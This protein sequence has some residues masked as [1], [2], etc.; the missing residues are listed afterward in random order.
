MDEPR[1][2]AGLL[3]ALGLGKYAIL[4]Q[5]EEVSISAHRFLNWDVG[6]SILIIIWICAT[7]IFMF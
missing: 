2:V 6:I 7:L 1:T 4:F 5:A 3:H